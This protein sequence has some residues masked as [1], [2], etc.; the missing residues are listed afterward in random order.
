MTRTALLTGA[1]GGIGR[2]V[3]ARLVA[4]GIKC[5]M[6]D[7]DADRLAAACAHLGPLAVPVAA[8]LTDFASLEVLLE[9]LVAEHGGF[10]ILFNNA[11]VTRTGHFEQ[12]T[13]ADILGEL[14]INF[15]SPIVLTRLAIPILQRAPDARIIT[16]VSLGGIFPL[17][18]TTVYSASKFGLRG[19]MLC[20]GLDGERLG[21]Q[22]GSVLPSATET[23]MLIREALEGGNKLQFMDPPQSPQDVASAVERLLDHPRLERYPRPSESW[24]V[25]LTMLAPNLL[26]R[27]LPLFRR[28]AEKGYRRYLE[29]L[30]KRG[31]T[32]PAR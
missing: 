3:A 14:Q 9:R 25:R 8:D 5:L 31:M 17:P 1:A 12:R 2:A 21:I 20:L 24:M 19:A 28:R 22:V 15:L 7:I 32:G 26:P 6:V 11:A 18:E 29:S 30:E 13:V 23:P 27:L 10:D 4:R 16:T